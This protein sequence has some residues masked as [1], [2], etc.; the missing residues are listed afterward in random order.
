MYYEWPL[1]HCHVYI[2]SE[3]IDLL[4]L[5]LNDICKYITLTEIV[6]NRFFLSVRLAPPDNADG[7]WCTPACLS[8]NWKKLAW[9]LGARST[10][11]HPRLHSRSWAA[12]QHDENKKTKHNEG[13]NTT[14]LDKYYT[15]FCNHTGIPCKNRTLFSNNRPWITCNI[16]GLLNMKKQRQQDLHQQLHWQQHHPHR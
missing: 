5:N 10:V 4:Y 2:T 3:E 1:I 12:K 11:P 9:V 7:S 8:I 13:N 6:E 16:K 15:N 14:L